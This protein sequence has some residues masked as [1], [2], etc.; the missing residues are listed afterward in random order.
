MQD[1]NAV[2]EAKGCCLPLFEHS[3]RKLNGICGDRAWKAVKK[4]QSCAADIRKEAKFKLI[5]A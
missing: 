1:S 2:S 4:I 5:L 3:Q